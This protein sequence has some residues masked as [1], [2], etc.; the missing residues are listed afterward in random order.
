MSG[1]GISVRDVAA[2][3]GTPKSTVSEMYNNNRELYMEVL[4]SAVRALIPLP[5]RSDR[6]ERSREGIQRPHGSQTGSP[7]R[8]LPPRSKEVVRCSP[9]LRWRSNAIRS[10]RRRLWPSVQSV[11]VGHSEPPV[12]GNRL[13]SPEPL[14]PRRMQVPTQKQEAPTSTSEGRVGPSAV[15]RG[16]SQFAPDST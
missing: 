12:K 6:R 7:L 11:G 14:C 15:G 8:L 4:A 3:T 16:S 13:R 10:V 1:E 9:R 2:E 5:P